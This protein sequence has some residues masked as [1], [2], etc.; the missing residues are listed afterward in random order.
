MSVGGADRVL[1]WDWR[2]GDVIDASTG[3][4]V[5]RIYVYPHPREPGRSTLCAADEGH[6]LHLASSRYR[7]LVETLRMLE[8]LRAA[9][10][11]EVGDG[12]V[13]AALRFLLRRVGR[14]VC[15]PEF[16]AALLFAALEMVGAYLDLRTVARACGA[17]ERGALTAL[18][19]LRR[20]LAEAGVRPRAPPSERVAALVRHYAEKLGVPSEVVRSA[21]RAVLSRPHPQ[22]FTPRSLALAVLFVELERRGLGPRLRRFAR[23]VGA[24][25]RSLSQAVRFARQYYYGDGG[26]G[27]RSAGSSGARSGAQSGAS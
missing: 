14:H 2:T 11:V 10:R 23:A 24:S 7:C 13:E 12:D 5:D 22:R 20:D 1:V 17:S 21:V 19:A 26:S 25:H 3:E 4:V 15:S 18:A 6:P 8:A 9:E 27:A 16:R